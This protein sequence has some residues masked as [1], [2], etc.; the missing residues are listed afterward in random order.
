MQALIAAIGLNTRDAC[1]R[2]LLDCVVLQAVHP[3][4]PA[5]GDALPVI[6]ALLS[7]GADASRTLDHLV[8]LHELCFEAT[9]QDTPPYRQAVNHATGIIPLLINA[10]AII[11][12]AALD[13]AKYNCDPRIQALLA[14]APINTT[15]GNN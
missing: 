8:D 3:L 12:P 9:A 15:R 7:E 1:G 11:S 14:L 6:R 5:Q 2:N 4:T 10:G 13:S